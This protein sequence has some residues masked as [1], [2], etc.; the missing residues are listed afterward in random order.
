MKYLRFEE[1][2]VPHLKTKRWYVKN[3]GGEV[4]GG[5]YWYGPWRKY[6]FQVAPKEGHFSGTPIFDK[7][8]LTEISDFLHE[9]MEARK[10][11]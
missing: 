10:K 5:I 3:V 6:V 1:I 9:Q 11:R 7:G 8:C 4:L 2:P